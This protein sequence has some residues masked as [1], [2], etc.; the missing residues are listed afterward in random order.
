MVW[1]GSLTGRGLA[2]CSLLLLSSRD[3]SWAGVPWREQRAGEGLEFWSGGPGLTGDKVPTQHLKQGWPGPTLTLSSTGQGRS[4]RT[5][6][7]VA[8]HPSGALPP[9]GGEVSCGRYRSPSECAQEAE[10]QASALTG[11][12]S[13][14]WRACSDHVVPR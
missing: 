6:F 11:E 5:I 10:L 8:L 9:A 7:Y 3:L 4:P 13:D 2:L 1:P 14:P 12:A